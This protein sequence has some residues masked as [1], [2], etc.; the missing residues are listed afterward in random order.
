M[1]AASDLPSWLSS[2]STAAT[3]VRVYAQP[4]AKK[5]AIVGE[6]NGMLKIALAAPPVEGK[7]NALLLKF[8]AKTLK[9]PKSALTLSSG[10]TS[11]N[12]AVLITGSEPREILAILISAQ[13]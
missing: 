5:T 12:K 10:E 4:G 3:L 9:L 8:L 11:R 2:K 7:A 1:P 6:F 13:A